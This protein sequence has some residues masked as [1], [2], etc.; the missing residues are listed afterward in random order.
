MNRPRAGRCSKPSS[1]AP[2][3]DIP[4][5]AWSAILLEMDA[6]C[7]LGDVARATHIGD[8]LIANQPQGMYAAR[9]RAI[10]NRAHANESK[11]TVKDPSAPSNQ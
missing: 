10:L 11:A 2:N 9:A 7:R 8:I 1:I 3:S 6:L 5:S 4:C